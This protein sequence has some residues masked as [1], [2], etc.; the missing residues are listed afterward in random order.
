MNAPTIAPR[1]TLLDDGHN[2]EL[3]K[4]WSVRSGK[5]VCDSIG[6]TEHGGLIGER[7]YDGGYW[8]EADCE[9]SPTD[10]GLWAEGFA[11]TYDEALSAILTVWSCFAHN[12]RPWAAAD[13]RP[14]QH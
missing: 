4:A 8:W 5:L 11:P 14:R 10:H 3:G 2:D 9:S 6:A 12:V 7:E 13:S 1:V